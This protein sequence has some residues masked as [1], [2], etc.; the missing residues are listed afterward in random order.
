MGLSEE[1]EVV[2]SLGDRWDCTVG[3][4]ESLGGCATV[5]FILQT[6]QYL[7]SY[8]SSRRST[9]KD[10]VVDCRCYQSDFLPGSSIPLIPSFLLAVCN[11]SVKF[12]FC[13]RRMLII[14]LSSTDWIHCWCDVD[15]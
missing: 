5:L 9:V 8:L 1:E 13:I 7:S 6:N 15:Y 10:D 11:Q 3:I 4:V 2:Q 12:V 14:F